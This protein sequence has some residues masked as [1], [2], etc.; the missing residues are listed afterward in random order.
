MTEMLPSEFYELYSKDRTDYEKRAEDYAIAT[1]PYLIRKDGSNKGTATPFKRAQSFCGGLVNTLRSKMGLALLPPSTSSFRFRVDSQEMRDAF[2]EGDMEDKESKSAFLSAL[3]DK[4]ERINSE[5]EVQQ[6]RPELF[7]LLEQ[8]LVVGSVVVEKMPKDGLVLHTLKSFA[9]KLNKRGHPLGICFVEAL[10]ES[11]LPEGVVIDKADKK[12][13]GEDYTLYTYVYENEDKKWVRKQEIDG[14]EV[15]KEVTY[16][17]YI[18]CPIHYLGWTWVAGDS[19]HRPYVEDYYDDMK[20]LNSLAEILTRGALAAAKIVFLVDETLG[21]T[22]KNDL[23]KSQT[24]DYHYGRA[25][26]VQVVQVGKNYDFQ[27]PMER[28]ANLKK[29]LSRMFLSS[30]SATRDAERVTAYEVSIMA[31][32][33]EGSTVGG[34][35]SSMALGFSKWLIHQMMRELNIKF[36]SATPEILTGLDALGR[37]QEAQKLDGYIQRMT[38]LGMMD[39][40][41]EEELATRYASYDSINTDGLVRTQK[42]VDKL[43]NTRQQQAL[44]AQNQQVAAQ[45]AGKVVENASKQG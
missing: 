24:G 22:N 45:T 7:R 2:G 35:Y 43:R 30:E 1:L 14:V 34:I 38:A 16:P 21:R 12:K 31:R 42:D 23:A 29:E 33:L 8:L 9:V 41:N 37:S 40:L 25:E 6:I 39:Y 5:I 26:D 18:D 13:K 32:E 20:Q 10:S 36:D 4:T 27:V 3:S 15:G 28:E 11:E 17:S 44:A 19:Y